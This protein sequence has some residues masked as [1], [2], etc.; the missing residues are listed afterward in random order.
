MNSNK[1]FVNKLYRYYRKN[2]N[3]NKKRIFIYENTVYY[4]PDDCVFCTQLNCTI[5][6]RWDKKKKKKLKSA[7]KEEYFKDYKYFETE[8][9]DNTDEYYKN[10]E[11]ENE[12]SDLMI[13][14][15]DRHVSLINIL[16]NMFKIYNKKKTYLNVTLNINYVF[17]QII[18]NIILYF[19]YLY[20][21]YTKYIYYIL[22]TYLFLLLYNSFHIIRENCYYP[23]IFLYNYYRNRIKKNILQ[24]WKMK[25]KKKKKKRKKKKH[26]LFLC[27]KNMRDTKSNNFVRNYS[28]KIIK[29]SYT[30]H[31]DDVIIKFLLYMFYEKFINKFNKY[32]NI[33]HHYHNVYKKIY[34]YKI[35]EG[36]LPFLCDHIFKCNY[37]LFYIFNRYNFQFNAYNILLNCKEK[38]SEQ[39]FIFFN[40]KFLIKKDY[41]MN[42]LIYVINNIR[43]KI[44]KIKII[45]D[46]T[47]KCYFIFYKNKCTS[48]LITHNILNVPIEGIK[49]KK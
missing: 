14:Y 39:I 28:Y 41:V 37:N 30:N 31:V 23:N 27:K 18:Y 29:D 36:M 3:Y 22:R 21:Y 34:Y 20:I 33:H 32:I 49:K 6:K 17:L 48:C 1:N 7:E 44:N 2:D 10:D 25:K 16:V 45:Y 40:K 11:E 12:A 43:E 38:N 4:T 19:V 42:Y 46:D 13:T 5:K 26:S 47:K 35:K 15:C 9:N 24:Q 8:N